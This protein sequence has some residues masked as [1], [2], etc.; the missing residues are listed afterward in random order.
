MDG[1]KKKF[2]NKTHTASIF[3]AQIG[4]PPNITKAYSK[5]NRSQ[6]K[7]SLAAPRFFLLIVWWFNI[8][9]VVKWRSFCQTDFLTA[10]IWNS[11]KLWCFENLLKLIWEVKYFIIILHSK[12]I[13]V[14]TLNTF[15]DCLDEVPKWNLI[16]LFGREEREKWLKINKLKLKIVGLIF[17]SFNTEEHNELVK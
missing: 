16:C 15:E 2:D 4:K 5:T 14:K 17:V 10:L 6:Y 13:Q 9:C 1:C 3:L 12:F 8:L 11:R 7:F